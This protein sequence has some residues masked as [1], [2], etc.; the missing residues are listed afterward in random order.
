[1]K[2]WTEQEIKYLRIYYPQIGPKK[3]AKKLGR[4]EKSVITQAHKQNLTSGLRDTHVPLV[5]IAPTGG[6]GSVLPSAKKQAERDG[7]LQHHPNRFV[8]LSV[9]T[10]WAD[11]YLHQKQQQEKLNAERH[12]WLT[13]RQIADMAG[14]T[15]V[16]LK[17]QIHTNQRLGRLLNNIDNYTALGQTGQ[18]RK[19]HPI[20]TREA[21]ATYRKLPKI[22]RNRSR[23]I[24][25]LL[26]KHHEMTI[27]EIMQHTTGS[28]Q[29][30]YTTLRN[31]QKQDIVTR[32]QDT[33]AP[34]TKP[35]Y[36]WRLT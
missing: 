31:L 35:P 9:P 34:D 32:R 6:Y 13:I 1:M 5:W 4:T 15:L 25:K 33:K 3:C 14:L 28:Y 30:I 17:K 23:N 21:I 10:W 22:D 7:V 2:L 16:A 26:K 18:P 24:I 36:L 29:V 20:Q 19:Y 27:H 8:E 12:D 11:Q